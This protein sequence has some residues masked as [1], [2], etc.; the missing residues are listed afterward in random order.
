MLPY[1]SHAVHPA[2]LL[3][4][5]LPLLEYI[6]LAVRRVNKITIVTAGRQ[7]LAILQQIGRVPDAWTV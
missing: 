3:L 4:L 2:S 7:D 1:G 6:K 5:P